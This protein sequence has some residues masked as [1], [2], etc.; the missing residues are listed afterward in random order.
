MMADG[1]DSGSSCIA[2]LEQ[3]SGRLGARAFCVTADATQ[4]SLQESKV[5][6]LASLMGLLAEIRNHIYELVLVENEA[7]DVSCTTAPANAVENHAEAVA[8][9]LKASCQQPPLTRVSQALLRETLPMFYVQ[10]SFTLN[11][12]VT[13]P[14]DRT[15]FSETHEMTLRWLG[16]IGAA[17]RR[18]INSVD[19]WSYMS[20]REQIEQITKLSEYGIVARIEGRKDDGLPGARCAVRL[21]FEDEESDA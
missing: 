20:S 5:T 13:I 3:V 9:G 10:N 16:C 2:Q 15:D 8:T 11:L 1:D 14:D 19:A 21:H 6:R 7:I 18:L 12:A 4:G 17:N